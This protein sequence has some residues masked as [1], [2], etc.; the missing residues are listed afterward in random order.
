MGKQGDK[1]R[2]R[3]KQRP[4]RPAAEGFRVGPLTVERHGKNLIHRVDTEHPDYAQFQQMMREQVENLPAELARLRSELRDLLAPFDAF[5]VVAYLWLINVPSDPETYRESSDEGM[6]AIPEVAAAILLERGEREG[7]DPMAYFWEVAERAQDLLKDYL[8]TQ[9]F[10]FMDEATRRHVDNPAYGEIRG[11]ARS[12]RLAVRGPTYWWQ[13]EQTI[14]DLFSEERIEPLVKAAAGFTAAE[15]IALGQA[16]SELGLDR[17]RK[18]LTEARDFARRLLGDLDRVRGGGQAEDPE[19]VAIIENL[20]GLDRKKAARRIAEMSLAWGSFA[21]GSVFE[22]TTDELAAAAG[23]GTAEATAFLSSFSISFGQFDE[24]T[25]PPELEDLRDNPILVDAASKHI[26]ASPHNVLWGL[27]PKLEEALKRQAKSFKIYEK[28]RASVIERRAVGALA[29]ALRADWAHAG[30]YYNVT[31]NGQTK[32]AELDGI[33][34]LD[35]VVYIVEVKA[36]SMRPSA[37]RAAPDALQDWL[38]DELAKAATQARRAHDA[39]F[40]TP[41]APVF[42]ERGRPIQLDLEEVRVVIEMV[43]T[44]EDLPAIAPLSWMLADAGLVPGDPVPWVVSLHELEIICEISQRPAELV[45]YTMRRRRLNERRDAWAVD[46]LD[47][48]MHYLLAGLYWEGDIR[49][50]PVR[51]LSH[52]DD[53]DAYYAYIKGQR[54]KKAKRPGPGHSRQVE[55]LLECLADLQTPGA[56]TASVAILDV[57]KPVRDRIA[58]FLKSLRRR[59]AQDGKPHDASLVAGDLGVT[60]MSVPLS[61]RD[62]LPRR[63][64]DYCR[65]KKHQMRAARWIG[66]GVF[67]GPSDPVQVAVVF[68]EPWQPDPE[69]DKLVEKLPSF[70]TEGDFDAR[71][72]AP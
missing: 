21:T 20:S 68:R 56:I 51:L 57:D 29:T 64:H 25:R 4:R 65:L 14:H 15:G 61:A 58:G 2:A 40:A 72:V 52:T 53:L 13:E 55:H 43:V 7:A 63:L 34:R 18:R 69:L 47:Y 16:M 44:L 1:R 37:R 70:G 3:K 27:R 36:A 28:H 8:F 12:H 39:L 41:S 24:S 59:S 11:L 54:Q 62:E 6:L 46:E 49:G 33:V 22:F 17:L 35:D 5:D 42:D 23:C 48:F 71:K 10:L 66:F 19:H 30:L 26:C 32:R 45:H 9:A 60:V 31:E 67:D 50:A 38:K